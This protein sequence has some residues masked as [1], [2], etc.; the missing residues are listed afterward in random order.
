MKTEKKI[1]LG[2]FA[3]V[4]AFNIFFTTKTKQPDIDLKRL[5][6]MAIA[7]DETDPVEDPPIIE[8]YSLDWFLDIIGF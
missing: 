5:S 8:P 6:N 7:T 3:G 2:L 4:F 1:L